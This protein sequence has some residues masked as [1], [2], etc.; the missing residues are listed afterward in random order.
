LATAERL[1]AERGIAAVPLRDIALAAGQRNN[2]AVQ[3]HFGD[4]EQLLREI[5]SHR[6]KASEKIR[7]EELAELLARGRA[8]E[9][10]DLVQ[11]FIRSLSGHLDEE[12]HYLAFLSRY[13]IER[14]G[15]GGLEGSVMTSTV[16]TMLSLLVRLLPEHRG[17]LLDERWTFTM[18]SSVHA[19]A[20]YQAAMRSSSLAAPLEEL[21]EDLVIVLSAGIEAP[22]RWGGPASEPMAEGQHAISGQ[23][24]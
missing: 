7:S 8:P 6:A 17:S 3:Y 2:V 19:L 14:G 23:R 4:R 16:S 24:G 18:T 11:A 15:Y 10:S 21:I 5:T 9:V 20:R 13:I 12:S 22:P 1:F